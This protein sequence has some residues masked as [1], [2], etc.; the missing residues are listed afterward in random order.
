[1]ITNELLSFCIQK[2]YPTLVS[3]VDFHVGYK[4]TQSGNQET[5]SEIISWESNERLPCVKTLV[6]KWGDLFSENIDKLV[7]TRQLKLALLDMGV[8]HRVMSYLSS[9]DDFSSYIEITSHSL[10]GSESKLIQDICDF[11]GSINKFELIKK[12]SEI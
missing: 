7:T 3:F 9:I 12:A 8:F 10:I 1:M 2:E 6:S 4:A 5:D 11:D